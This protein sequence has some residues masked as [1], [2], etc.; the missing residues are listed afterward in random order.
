MNFADADRVKKGHEKSG[1]FRD[2]RIQIPDVVVGAIAFP[3]AAHSAS[4]ASPVKNVRVGAM[5]EGFA[6]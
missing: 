3:K 1:D 2:Q 4:F 5:I 6:G